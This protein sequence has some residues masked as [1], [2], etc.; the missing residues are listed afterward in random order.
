MQKKI[1]LS[2]IAVNLYVLVFAGLRIDYGQQVTAN[3]S[4]LDDNQIR[5][6]NKLGFTLEQMEQL[7]K[8]DGIDQIVFDNRNIFPRFEIEFDTAL[9]SARGISIEED[10]KAIRDLDYVAGT[11]PT[12]EYQVIVAQSLADILLEGFELDDIDKLIGHEFVKGLTIVGVYKDTKDTSIEEFD[13][14]FIQ[15]EDKS[16]KEVKNYNLQNSFMFFNRGTEISKDEIIRSINTDVMWDYESNGQY[17]IIVDT[18]NDNDPNNDQEPFSVNY[19]E[20]VANG[21]KGLIDPETKVYGDTINQYAFINTSN[22]R[23]KVVTSLQKQFPDAA[24]ITSDTK[25]NDIINTIPNWFK[26]ILAAIVLELLIFVPA[27]RKGKN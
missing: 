26:F 9:V 8:V 17:D 23:D 2:L 18:L 19:E 1:I 5:M 22:D 21:A 14:S 15:E 4:R 27:I 25:Y 11:F 10:N 24:I 3:V 6:Y 20:S 16:F 12:E 7:E 13:T